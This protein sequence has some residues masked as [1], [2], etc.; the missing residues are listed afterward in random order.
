[1][2]AVKL[3]QAAAVDKDFGI[4]LHVRELAAELEG[5]LALQIRNRLLNI[6]IGVGRK[7]LGTV[8]GRA[9]RSKPKNID[10]RKASHR[11]ARVKDV[12][13]AI[14]ERV[15]VEVD[16]LEVHAVVT[17]AQFVHPAGIGSVNPALDVRPGAYRGAVRER[18]VHEG[19]VFTGGIVIAQKERA[20]DGIFVVEVNVDFCYPVVA[21]VVVGEAAEEV[22]GGTVI[23]EESPCAS[24]RRA[25]GAPHQA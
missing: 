16:K 14:G 12:T 8:C 17:E 9:E 23:R 22:I 6:V 5:V 2:T 19:M 11:R 15:D 18:N 3:D 20:K 25:C 10:I 21:L 7:I 13:L 1:M 24:W 4:S